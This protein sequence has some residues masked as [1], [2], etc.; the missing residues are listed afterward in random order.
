M[1]LKNN[2]TA[3]GFG[4]KYFIAIVSIVDILSY[5]IT[6]IASFMGNGGLNMTIFLG[7]NSKVL[8]LW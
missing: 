4:L 5:I 1:M 8:K 7:V 2:L 6:L 3:P